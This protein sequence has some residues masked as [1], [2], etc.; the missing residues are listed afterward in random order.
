MLAFGALIWIWLHPDEAARRPLTKEQQPTT[1]PDSG[2]TAAAPPEAR[3]AAS[4][5]H[6]GLTEFTGFRDWA[7]SYLSAPSDQREAMLAKGPE[8]ASAHI[9]ERMLWNPTAAA[10]EDPDRDG[11]SNLLEFLLGGIPIG[12]NSSDTSILP[13][14]VLTDTAFVFTF[15]QSRTAAQDLSTVIETSSTFAASDWAPVANES[16]KTED[17]GNLTDLVTATIPRLPGAGNFFVRLK[18]EPRN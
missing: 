9:G 16:I 2:S 11:I 8:L 7:R 6:P 12:T 18:G 3:S 17:I 5:P 15:R 13:G 10:S 4:T 1:A 14:G